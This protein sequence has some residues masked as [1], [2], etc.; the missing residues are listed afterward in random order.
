MDYTLVLIDNP[1]PHVRRVTLNRP[2]K[3]NA[4]NSVLR[5]EVI[6]AVRAG[7]SDPDVRVSVIAANGPSFCGGYDLT[8]NVAQAG[9]ATPA[10]DYPYV[11]AGGFQRSVVDLWTSMWDL[12]KP[13]IAQGELARERRSRTAAPSPRIHRTEMLFQ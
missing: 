13:V 10:A 1:A 4:L 2:E 5:Q 9:T 7:E 12:S 6:T 8:Q 3:R 11:G